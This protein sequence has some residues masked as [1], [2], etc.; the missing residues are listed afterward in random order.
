MS[1]L[2]I[3]LGAFATAAALG[4]AVAS[5]AGVGGSVARQRFLRYAGDP[6]AVVDVQPLGGP[7][8]RLPKPWEAFLERAGIEWSAARAAQ[9]AGMYAA[10]GLVVA[11]PLGLA[12]VGPVAGLAAL[13]IKLRL[14]QARRTRKMAEQL[15]DALML[16]ATAL[17]SGLGFQQAL[18]LVADEG[19]LPLAPEL[20]RLSRDMKIGLSIEEALVRLQTRLG[21]TDGEMLAAA[22]LVQRQTGGN[23]VEL[24]TNLHDT[25][26]D[27]QAVQGQVRTLTAQGRLSGM[28]LTAIPVFLAL[29]FWVLNR[30]YL[31]VLVQDPRGRILSGVA[32]GLMLVGV[33]F[34]RRI[35]RITL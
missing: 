29:A 17:R 20:G 8:V 19:P 22:L 12:P 14:A 6:V 3:S 13:W 27:R 30:E 35:V 28:V 16:M 26:R 24:L 31:L 32:V 34:I 15:P 21:S 2:L 9:M 7:A 23:L 5:W 4:W 33:Y 10:I 1:A 25:I 18:Q 11:L